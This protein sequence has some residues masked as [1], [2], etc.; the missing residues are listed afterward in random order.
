[1]SADDV[2]TMP[3]TL[4]FGDDRSP[5]SDVAWGWITAQ[6][7]PDW[8]VDVVRV[9]EPEPTIESL[10]SHEPLHEDDRD[11]PRVAPE[12]SGISCVR[13][14]TTAYD[15][16]I[17]LNGKRD[18]R[19]MVVGARGRGL[20]KSMRIGSTA[21]W[22]MR[23]PGTPLVVARADSPVRRILVC[24][25]GSAHARAAVQTIC[26]LPWL[27]GREVAVLTVIDAATPSDGPA[28]EAAGLLET[29]GA[30]T[31]VVVVEPELAGVLPSPTYAIL[32]RIDELEPDLV[33]IGTRGLTGLRRLTIGSVAGAV[34]HAAP[35]S[36]LLT[37]DQE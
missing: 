36:V 29:A 21:E 5:G 28:E 31:R 14:L 7:W 18:G 26:D 3:Q 17:V 24:V 19:L 4:T 35:C 12:S 30:S 13:H 15:P 25:D 11:D 22:L 23:S 34:A 9:T 8:S 16:R 37:R 32:D 27:P 6:R 1:M 10:F 33:A 20:L 2:R